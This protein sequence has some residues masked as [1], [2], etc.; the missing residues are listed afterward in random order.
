MAKPR[1]DFKREDRIRNE[2]IVDTYNAEDDRTP[3]GLGKGT[4]DRRIRSVASGRVLSQ[5]RLGGLHHRFDRA[6]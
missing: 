3:L 1:R 4:P 5:V 6:A 2:V